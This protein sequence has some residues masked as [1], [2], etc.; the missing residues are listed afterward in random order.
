MTPLAYGRRSL[1]RMPQNG[2]QNVED[3]RREG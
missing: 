1:G 3:W 2:Q